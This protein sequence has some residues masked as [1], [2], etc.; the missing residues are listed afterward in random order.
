MCINYLSKVLSPC[1]Q[2]TDR[3][4]YFIELLCELSVKALYMSTVTDATPPA[5]LAVII[6]IGVQ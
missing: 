6:V 3:I 2:K 5:V 1:L 4:R